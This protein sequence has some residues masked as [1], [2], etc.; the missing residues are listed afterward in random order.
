MGQLSSKIFPLFL[1]PIC[2][3]CDS[4]RFACLDDFSK[5]NQIGFKDL[6]SKIDFFSSLI[7]FI[8]LDQIFIEGNLHKI[9]LRLIKITGNYTRAGQICENSKKNERENSNP[10]KFGYHLSDVSAYYWILLKRYNF[11]YCE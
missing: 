11:I 2:V 7:I 10:A 9:R 4:T 5:F 8:E 1:G 6:S 3:F